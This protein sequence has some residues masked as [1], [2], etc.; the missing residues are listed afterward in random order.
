MCF[1]TFLIHVWRVLCVVSLCLCV[2]CACGVL[3]FFFLACAGLCVAR[4][5]VNFAQTLPAPLPW[6]SAPP[7]PLHPGERR[8]PPRRVVASHPP[9]RPHPRPRQGQGWGPAHPVQG[10][11]TAWA[12]P[13]GRERHWQGQAAWLWGGAVVAEL[14]GVSRRPGGQPPGA[15]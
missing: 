1:P 13:P 2:C 15:K 9:P 6:E 4:V 14:L 12:C 3:S 5:P 7:S 8:A 11:Q 10:W